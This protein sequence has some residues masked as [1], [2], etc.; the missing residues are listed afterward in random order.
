M[1]LFIFRASLGLAALLVVGACSKAPPPAEPLRPVLTTVLGE[2]ADD[3]AATYSGDVRSRYET[4]LSF[5]ISGK[6]AARLVDAGAHVAAGDV[7]ARLDPADTALSA[8]A[9]NAQLELADADLRRYRELRAKNFVSQSALDA[10]ETTFK[11]TRAQADLARNQ[12]AYTVLRADQAGVVELVAAEV[13]Q[14]VAAGQPV[15]RVART[16][17]LEVAVA[18]PESRMPLRLKTAQISLWSDDQASYPGVLRELSAVADP[19]TRTYAARVSIVKPDSRVLLGMTAKVKFLS[20]R[21]A[22][23]E[24]RLAVPLTAIFQQDG[25]TALWVVGDDQTLALR[26]VSVAAYGETTATLASGAQG[27]VHAGER[28]VVAG[29]H[30]LAAGEK[31]KVVDQ[32]PPVAAASTSSGPVAR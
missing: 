28:I 20:D 13:G 12:S 31:I 18:I 17:T 25:R 22:A 27:G 14:V 4:P 32:R 26:A 16:D 7:L 2:R 21:S 1:T 10:K 3:P 23:D 8:A 19:A 6:I 5:R 11:A 30:K 15:M 29:V 9:A 24:S